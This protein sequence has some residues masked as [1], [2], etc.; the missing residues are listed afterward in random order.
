MPSAY[1]GF[2]IDFTYAVLSH[3]TSQAMVMSGVCFLRLLMT[4]QI[5]WFRT[6]AEA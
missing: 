1:D 2:E 4:D 6:L 5:L 3:D